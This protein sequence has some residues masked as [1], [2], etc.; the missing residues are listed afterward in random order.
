MRNIANRPRIALL[1][2]NLASVRICIDCSAF[3]ARAKANAG[4]NEEAMHYDSEY[5]YY[6]RVHAH[7]LDEI[8]KLRR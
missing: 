8:R 1:L 2:N 4:D 5:D 3:L 6:K 7:I